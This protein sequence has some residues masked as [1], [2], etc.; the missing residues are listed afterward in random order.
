VACGRAGEQ[1]RILL[2]RLRPDPAG[3]LTGGRV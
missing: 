3:G 2:G 1:A